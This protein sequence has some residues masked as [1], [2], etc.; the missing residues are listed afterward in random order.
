MLL[1]FRLLLSILLLLALLLMAFQL[2]LASL[3]LLASPQTLAPLL[4]LASL[5]K[6]V[7]LHTVLYRTMR[8][9]RLLDY[10]GH[11]TVIIF[12]YRIGLSKIGLANLI[13]Y[14]IKSSFGLS[15]IGLKKLSIAQLCLQNNGLS[16]E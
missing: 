16:Y 6:L 8:H 2:L 14:R 3:Q 10:Y 11:R 12:C 15:D 9:I 13:N 4:I 7:F 1:A 5:F